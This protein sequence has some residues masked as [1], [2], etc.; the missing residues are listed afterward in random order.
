M[1]LDLANGGHLT[2][3][4]KLNFSGKLY[5]I[6]GYKVRQDTE[7]IDYDALEAQAVAG[8]SRR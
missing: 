3:G 7:V 6:A 2:H 1:G 4:H 5:R 8:N